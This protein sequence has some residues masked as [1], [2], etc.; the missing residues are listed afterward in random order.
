[1]QH[2]TVSLF[3]LEHGA[4]MNKIKVNLPGIQNANTN[5]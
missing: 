1:M 2:L 4:I 5:D 3:D